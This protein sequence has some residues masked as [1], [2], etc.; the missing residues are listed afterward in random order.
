MAKFHRKHGKT[1]GKHWKTQETTGKT[2][3]NAERHGNTRAIF[4]KQWENMGKHRKNPKKE[5]KN[6]YFSQK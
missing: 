4:E 3:K 5:E 1:L 6:E 2:N